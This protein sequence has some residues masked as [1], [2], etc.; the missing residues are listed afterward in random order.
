M[1]SRTSPGSPSIR[2]TRLYE[3]FFTYVIIISTDAFLFQLS[4]IEPDMVAPRE[5]V[6]I[7]GRLNVILIYCSVIVL[8][9]RNSQRVNAAIRSALPLFALAGLAFLSCLWAPDPA[10]TLRRSI[11]LL[12][13][14]MTVVTMVALLPPIRVIRVL[15]VSLALCMIFSVLWVVLMPRYGMHNAADWVEPV[16]AGLWRGIYPHKNGLGNISCIALVTLLFCGKRVIRSLIFRALAISASIACLIGAHSS[17]GIV[18]AGIMFLV[19]FFF[20]RL[21]LMTKPTRMFIGTSVLILGTILVFT[22]FP[23]MYIVLDALGKSTDLTGR[24]PIWSALFAWSSERP[25]MG[26]GYSTGFE[27][28][29]TPRLHEYMRLQIQSAH[30]GYLEIFISFGY[31]GL[32]A[33]ILYLG[34]FLIKIIKGLSL[35]GKDQ[36]IALAYSASIFFNSIFGNITESSFML[37]NN[38]FNMNA[39]LAYI[40]LATMLRAAA[41]SPQASLQHASPYSRTGPPEPLTS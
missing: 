8:Y 3:L 35:S 15:A 6:S 2:N 31:V 1:E 37:Q 13:N 17:T 10:V 26:Y 23:L 41:P 22:S 40:L 33:L 29:M 28:V 39:A 25:L 4:G 11:A 16:H 19:F 32:M 14:F 21:E 34:S 20:R 27:Y 38:F 5:P 24:L 12:F 7:L 30:N 18:L 36:N 9:F